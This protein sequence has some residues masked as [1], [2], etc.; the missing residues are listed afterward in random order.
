MKEESYDI[1]I[2]GGGLAGL[3]LAYRALKAG[4]WKEKRIL[5]LDRDSK[6][7]NDRTWCF[8]QAGACEFEE[9]VHRSWPDMRVWTNEG[10]EIRLDASPYVYKMIRGGDFYRH[11]LG[12]LAQQPQVH[13]VQA[14]IRSIRQSESLCF[15]ETPDALYSGRYLFSS[16]YQKPALAVHHQYFLQHFKGIVIRPSQMPLPEDAMYL[17]D[18]RANQSQGTA[19]FYTLP[20][21]EGRLFVEYTL[22]SK[23]LLA[24]GE[25]DAALAEY[26]SQVLGISAHEVLE[27]EFGIIPMT[28]YP[29]SRR[30]GRIL[31][32]GS[33]GG[34]TRAS[35]GYTFTNVQ[36]TIGRILDA[37]RAGREPWE[38][39]EALRP[40]H[41]LMDRTLLNVLDQGRYPGHEI[42]SDLYVR[43]PAPILFRFLDGASSLPEDLRVMSSVRWTEFI[44]PFAGALLK[45]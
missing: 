45:G 32:L 4:V 14:E 33:A 44:K 8:W 5:L 13:F 40:R 18:F 31:H 41:H 39:E 30:E 11:A 38:F 6:S 1:L 24:E 19:F 42:F 35:S 17:M 21:G 12:Y 7:R 27:E 26:I 23:S 29:F 34:D 3:S 20:M 2:A 10:R 15:A 36:R 37:L 25:Y 22:F 28:D 9:I 16:L 43:T